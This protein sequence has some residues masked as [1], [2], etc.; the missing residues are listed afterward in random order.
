MQF[1]LGTHIVGA[2]SALVIAVF[3]VFSAFSYGRRTA[4]YSRLLSGV[5]VINMLS[6]LFLAVFGKA[7]VASVC[8]NLALYAAL[9]AMV[10]GV[11]FWRMRHRE[12]MFSSTP[13]LAGLG[14][15]AAFT[16][17]ALLAGF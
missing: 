15:P 8:D 4:A 17:I 11:V 10:Q 3:A 7:S 14:I 9:Y 1:L 12:K 16:T 6:G 2:L 5:F 13:L